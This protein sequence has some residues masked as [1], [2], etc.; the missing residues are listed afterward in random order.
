MSKGIQSWLHLATTI[1]TM[2]IR[3]PATSC[4]PCS[5]RSDF[6]T[7]KKAQRL[8]QY[9]TFTEIGVEKLININIF[10]LYKNSYKWSW[11]FVGMAFQ[12]QNIPKSHWVHRKSCKD[13]RQKAWSSTAQRQFRWNWCHDMVTIAPNG[14]HVTLVRNIHPTSWLWKT[15]S[16]RHDNYNYTQL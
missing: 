4:G 12:T 16:K 6:S 14:H 11:M 5:K 10:I 15:S 3:R 2:G 13:K 1:L 8:Q 9:Q 7:K